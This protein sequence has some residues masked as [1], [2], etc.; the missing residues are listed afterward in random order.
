MNH[1]ELQLLEQTLQICSSYITKYGR[2]DPR[3]VEAEEAQKMWRQLNPIPEK[4]L[5][6]S[7]T[8]SLCRHLDRLLQLLEE[9]GIVDARTDAIQLYVTQ[10]QLSRVYIQEHPGPA[11][12][13]GMATANMGSVRKLGLYSSTIEEDLWG[14]P[15]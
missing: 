11:S 12:D 2:Y 5:S 4:E 9:E 8:A 1:P 6:P 10:K 15:R 3:R 14:A 13:V 7:V